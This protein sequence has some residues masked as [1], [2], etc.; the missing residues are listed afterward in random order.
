MEVT[1]N[2]SVRILAP[3]SAFAV[4]LIATQ[5][6]LSGRAEALTPAE[7]PAECL[8]V[9]PFDYFPARFVSQGAELTEDIPTF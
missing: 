7:K 3:V 6:A 9:A 4:L 5:W 8:D 2:T 1:M